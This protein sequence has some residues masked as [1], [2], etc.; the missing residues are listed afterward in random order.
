MATRGALATWM[1][2]ATLVCGGAAARRTECAPVMAKRIGPDRGTI[3]TNLYDTRA[4]AWV[5]VG[6]PDEH[7]VEKINTP[8]ATV[9]Q[10]LD[11]PPFVP[12]QTIRVTHRSRAEAGGALLYG[13]DSIDGVCRLKAQQ[14]CVYLIM[15]TQAWVRLNGRPV[16][17]TREL[18][19]LYLVPAGPGDHIR[20]LTKGWGP[21]VIAFVCEGGARA[22]ESEFPLQAVSAPEHDYQGICR[23]VRGQTVPITF[24][25][26]RR[27]PRPVEP[28]AYELVVDAPRALRAAGAFGSG[29]KTIAVA[30]M[31]LSSQTIVRDGHPY[32]RHTVRLAPFL[33]QFERFLKQNPGYPQA[34]F[35]GWATVYVA[36]HVPADAPPRVP[37]VYWHIQ[38]GRVA[39]RV[40]KLVVEPVAI[41]PGV[42]VPKGFEV[43][44]TVRRFYETDPA[45]LGVAYGRLLERCGIGTVV[46][47][48][49]GTAQRMKQAG[50][51]T[52][53]IAP[54]NSG[55]DGID[56][57]GVKRRCCTQQRILDGGAYFKGRFFE[58][59]PDMTQAFDGY[60]LDFEPR[61]ARTL[62]ACF[63]PACRKAFK[64]FSGTDIST[65]KP[66]AIWKTMQDQWIAFR[67]WQH[68]QVFRL[69]RK[70]VKEI[71]P[72][73]RVCVNAGGGAGRKELDHIARFY[74]VRVEDWDGVADLYGTYFYG[75]TPIFMDGFKFFNKL[76]RKTRFA[77][78]T[79]MSYGVGAGSHVL[80]PKHLR[81]QMFLWYAMRRVARGN[82]TPRPSQNRT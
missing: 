4:K 35:I 41:K 26:A 39:S 42:R 8:Y 67:Q 7:T 10:R 47:N 12:E 15:A 75:N 19:A 14:R 82:L 48:S 37:P 81:L 31:R 54:Y 72:D 20:F 38:R 62:E 17:P 5:A 56:I 79:A 51:A 6:Q 3:V 76:F 2:T 13:Y 58:F 70:A 11:V 66:K 74:G 33:T 29:D 22:P 23:V 18:G 50:L 64:Q 16:A 25:V 73:Y 77:P 52:L 63:C 21:R 49:K 36:L 55:R 9:F 34:N 24:N 61:G 45:E 28:S 32:G 44:A 43:H 1:A 80:T 68:R 69:Y 78:W 30:P 71:R 65:L 27:T 53:F 57:N 40:R 60:E 46:T 59:G